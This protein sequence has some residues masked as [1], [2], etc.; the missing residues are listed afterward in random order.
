MNRPKIPN[1]IIFT[2]SEESF[3]LHSGC[4]VEL[5]GKL[6][7][8]TAQDA[9]LSSD[10]ILY[11]CADVGFS[12]LNGNAAFILNLEESAEVTLT[13]DTKWIPFHDNAKE[14][15]LDA[16]QLTV[17]PNPLLSGDVVHIV[18]APAGFQQDF[19]Q[20]IKRG[21]ISLY[22]QATT[23]FATAGSKLGFIHFTALHGM[24]GSPVVNDDGNLVGILL[25]NCIDDPGGQ[26]RPNGLSVVSLIP[27]LD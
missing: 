27:N 12:D 6:G 17:A 5:D 20:Q 4:V 23:S 22:F 24:L 10:T 9:P 8:L 16:Y 3:S 2:Q 13:E 19:A 26:P 15:N 11:I 7:L 21:L 14:L 25:A 1:V 18:G